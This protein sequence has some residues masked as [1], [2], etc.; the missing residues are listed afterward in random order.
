MFRLNRK[1]DNAISMLPA[2]NPSFCISSMHVS[3][4]LFAITSSNPSSRGKKNDANDLILVLA[5]S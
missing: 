1:L 4:F 5:P 2:Q 3:N